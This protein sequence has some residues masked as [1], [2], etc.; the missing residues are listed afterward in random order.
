LAAH[1]HDR[2]FFEMIAE[3]IK[4]SSRASSAS[5]SRPR[6]VASL[7]STNRKNRR[8]SFDSLRQIFARRRKSFAQRLVSLD[9]VCRDR[10]RS[11]NQLANILNVSESTRQFLHKR[12]NSLR[13]DECAL[14]EVARFGGIVHGLFEYWSLNITWDL[15]F[16]IWDLPSRP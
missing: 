13:K 8:L 6:L 11:P 15:V 9:P 1:V 10:A 16:G 5:S 3:K 4:V 7:I 12:S 14:L 2:S